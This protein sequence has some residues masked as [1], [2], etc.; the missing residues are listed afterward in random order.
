VQSTTRDALLATGCVGALSAALGLTASLSLLARPVVVAVGVTAGLAVEAL[1]VADTPAAE[2]WER[3]AVQAASVV[4]L[5]G[6]AG[7]AVWA[8]GPW[9]VAVVWWGLATYF[10]LLALLVAGV[11][12]PKPA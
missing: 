7:L 12:N 1:F 2:L 6:G 11:W 8:G 9:A 10:L 4:A 3:P 5:V